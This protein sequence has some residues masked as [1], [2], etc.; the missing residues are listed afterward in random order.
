METEGVDG[1]LMF[2]YA[3]RTLALMGLVKT[4]SYPVFLVVIH[5]LNIPISWALY[6]LWLTAA[7]LTALFFKRITRSKYFSSFVFVIVLYLPVAFDS[8]VGQRLYRNIVFAPA[9]CILIALLALLILSILKNRPHKLLLTGFSVWFVFCYYL[10]E[11]GIWLIP[12]LLVVLVAGVYAGLRRK[13]TVKVRLLRGGVIVLIPLIVFSLVTV[14]YRSV[15]YSIT[16]VPEIETRTQGEQGRFISN[17]YHID[18]KN[19]TV[20]NWI[21][22]TV[23]EQAWE[24]SDTLKEEYPELGRDLIDAMQKTET[25]MIDGDMLGWELKMLVPKYF[26]ST[27]E[28]EQVMKQVNQ[29]L[30]EAFEAG[31]IQRTS[32]LSLTQS[33]PDKSLAEAIELAKHLPVWL[34]V[35][36]FYSDQDVTL[37]VISYSENR[38][39]VEEFASITLYPSEKSSFDNRLATITIDIERFISSGYQF[40]LAPLLVLCMVASVAILIIRR[41]RA[42][43]L[44]LLLAALFCMG[45]AAVYLFGIAFFAEWI[46]V[47]LG[48][49]ELMHMKFYAVSAAPLLLFAELFAAAFLVMNI[50]QK[51]A[52]ASGSALSSP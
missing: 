38:A 7:V 48:I 39:L 52:L 44:S 19:R 42:K 49:P 23:I 43:G 45:Y 2:L 11:N 17:L 18:D 3:N 5:L 20:T 34:S 6:L 27:R 16:G 14:A 10:N 24:A 26:Q 15:A 29:E 35:H 28:I 50:R 13:G 8:W 31:T 40:V 12:M 21:P 9:T 47:S 51:A 22:R 25:G 1:I 41:K 30:D 32:G 4:L 33:A 37:P 46:W 36:M